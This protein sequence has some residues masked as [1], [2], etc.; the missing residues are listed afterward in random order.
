MKIA[1][2]VPGQGSEIP[3]M[4]L[5][6]ATRCA[7]GRALLDRASEVTGQDVARLLQ[8]GGPALGR[9]EVLQPTL[10]AVCL[11]VV[12]ALRE[13]GMR[14]ELVAGHSLGE[15]GAWSASGSITDGDAVDL[16]ALRGRLM[17]RQASHFPGAMIA[18]FPR[19]EAQLDD[20][21]RKSKDHGT[22][23]VAAHNSPDEWVLSGDRAAVR[24]AA[25]A[26]RSSALRTTGPW[27]SPA[28]QGA[29]DEFRQALYAVR[30]VPPFAGFVCNRTGMRIEDAEQIPDLLAGQLVRPVCWARALRTLVDQGA[31]DLVVAGPGKILR[32]LIRKNLGTEVAVHDTDRLDDLDRTVKVLQ[33]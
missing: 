29:V 4:G 10:T 22:I 3:G 32:G 18:V 7:H 20:I 31:T 21:V 1:V 25:A 23:A 19:D 9:T 28:M 8:R 24:F 14:F 27:H 2:L 33:Q 26:I 11:S 13:A 12:H 5:A 15:I 30:R 6:L 17:A 16:A